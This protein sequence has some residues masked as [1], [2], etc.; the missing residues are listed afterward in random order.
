[1]RLWVVSPQVNVAKDTTVGQLV[2]ALAAKFAIA[3]MPG[4]RPGCRLWDYYGKSRWVIRPRKGLEGAA[5]FHC[6]TNVLL[7]VSLSLSLSL[8]A[9]LC[10]SRVRFRGRACNGVA[11]RYAL[12]DDDDKCLKDLNIIANQDLFLEEF[13][14]DM[15]K[16][17]YSSEPERTVTSTSNNSSSNNYASVG[18]SSSS[19]SYTYADENTV[20]GVGSW[21]LA[22]GLVGLTNIGN[23]CFMNS[24]VQC[25]SACVPLR[26]L[27]RTEPA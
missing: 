21:P 7:L 24:V 10:A 15:G 9:Y 25:L 12:F 2:A 27:F 17:P 8:S 22:P 13:D 14:A 19:S 4:G 3:P 18:Y 1:M 26:E 5:P 6:V 23:T 20:V 11:V 16:W